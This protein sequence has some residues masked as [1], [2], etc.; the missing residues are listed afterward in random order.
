LEAETMKPFAWWMRR[1]VDRLGWPGGI[2]LAL[3]IVAVLVYGAM[4]TAHQSRLAAIKQETTTLKQRIERAAKSG[5]PESGSVDEL[6]KFYGFFASATLTEW[7]DKLYAAADAEKL[8]L[9]QGEYR[10]VADKSGKLTRYQVTLPVK[11]SYAQIR[12][13]IDMAL[14]AVP[15][16]ALEDVN[17]KREAIGSAELE[18]RI[19]FTLFLGAQ[20]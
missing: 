5:I 2:G 3:V 4:V 19:K 12:R 14:I 8:V 1:A 7:L 20:P 6:K 15:V 9:T 17:F 16:A 13:F 18:A 10:S 11:G